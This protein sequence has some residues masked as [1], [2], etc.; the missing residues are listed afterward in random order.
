MVDRDF[1]PA[2]GSF[3]PDLASPRHGFHWLRLGLTLKVTAGRH[4]LEPFSLL[5]VDAV[6][7]D[8]ADPLVG[9]DD[10][11][12]EPT[13]GGIFAPGE[14]LGPASLCYQVA[15]PPGGSVSLVWVPSDQPLDQLTIA[16]P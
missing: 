2:A 15:D 11:R 9:M 13:P 7:Q 3:S 6:G 14:G 1:H 12:C 10:P 8:G 16:L 4:D 5:A